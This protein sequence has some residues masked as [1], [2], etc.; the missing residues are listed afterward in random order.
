[1][2]VF[3]TGATGFIGLELVEYFLDKS[4][5]VTAFVRN[6]K[7]LCHISQNPKLNIIDAPLE[8]ID[9]YRDEI[10]SSQ[11]VVHLS[12]DANYGNG[13]HYLKVN[14]D[15]TVKLVDIL[16][17]SKN[18]KFIFYS[19]MGAV[20]RS[21]SDDCSI[22]LNDK[23]KCYPCTDYG[24]SKRK[25]E[26]YIEANL[27]NYSIIRPAM[28]YGEKMRE[29]S[30]ISFFLQLALKNS[31]ISK[32]NFPS[33]YS[34]IHVRDVCAMTDKLLNNDSDKKV[35]YGA[36]DNISLGDIFGVVKKPLLPVEKLTV[37]I[38]LFRAF[39]PFKVK[40]LFLN[41]LQVNL[42]FKELITGPSIF[43]QT[44]FDSILKRE[45]ARSDISA[46]VPGVT[47]VT[48]AN[49][50]LGF[51]FSDKLQNRE[52]LVLIDKNIEHINSVY[53]G[54]RNIRVIACDFS[55]EEEL[56]KLGEEKFW[57]NISEIFQCAGF[58]LRGR[59][60]Q[61]NIDAQLASFKVNLLARIKL[62]HWSM[63]SFDRNHFG[64]NVFVSSSTAFQGMPYMS[65]YAA[66]N[67]GLLNFFTGYLG[68]NIKTKHIQN[69]ILCPGG[70]KTSFQKT[71]GVKVLENEK[72][73]EPKD[74]VEI[75][76]SKIGKQEIIIFPSRSIAM[77]ILSRLLPYKFQIKI[78]EKLMRGLR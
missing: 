14:Y 41:T 65:A 21:S 28:V 13:E 54:R 76:M 9:D 47:V 29:A 30:H 22:P 67:A 39:I 37:F 43:E 50:G 31:L 10:F 59:F 64:R 19:T 49:S 75:V 5:Y 66:S 51:S 8:S 16:K 78:W 6:P 2:K 73:S 57:N 3:V 55:N 38:K 52:N 12:G 56:I 1:M 18:T 60:D 24:K 77:L 68:E 34:V 72:L 35:F 33:I 53:S 15:P 63:S 69:L 32:M 46:M 45:K 4:Y 48:G 42:D 40:S 7:K 27:S 25:C 11:A 23:S 74:V 58:G 36:S 26:E 61:L 70:M 17:D 44:K 71:A 62:L 20:E